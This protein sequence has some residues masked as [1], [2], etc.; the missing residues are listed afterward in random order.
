MQGYANRDSLGYREVYGLN[1]VG[2]LF[3]GTLRRFVHP[4]MHPSFAR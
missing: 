1:D 4:C 3:R 2:T